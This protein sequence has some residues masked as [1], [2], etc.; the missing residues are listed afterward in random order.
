M[1]LV[2][3]HWLRSATLKRCQTTIDYA[4]FNIQHTLR[5]QQAIFLAIS[6]RILELWGD[7]AMAQS[8]DWCAFA[9]RNQT[10]KVPNEVSVRKTVQGMFSGNRGTNV[11]NTILNVVYYLTIAKQMK[12]R[13]GL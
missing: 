10:C 12:A 3:S 2:H 4:D 8:T 1:L 11:T 9:S 7:I 5:A 6:R 13:L